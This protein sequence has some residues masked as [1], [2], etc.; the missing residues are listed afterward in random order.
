[1]DEVKWEEQKATVRRVEA[2]LRSTLLGASDDDIW[3]RDYL[4]DWGEQV[5]A[6]D[7]TDVPQNIRGN[8]PDLDDRLA[9]TA[10]NFY[11]PI[12]VTPPVVRPP[13]QV[14]SYQPKSIRDILYDWAIARLQPL[15]GG[16]STF[17]SSVSGSPTSSGRNGASSRRNETSTSSRFET[18]PTCSYSVKTPSSP[19]RAG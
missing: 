18:S 17:M 16:Y 19:R 2:T 6:L 10:F 7:L 11:D 1:M 14:S 13:A 12:P 15:I 3:M 9:D 4:H 5:D 8:A